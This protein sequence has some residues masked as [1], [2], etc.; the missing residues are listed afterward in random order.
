[1][2]CCIRLSQLGSK[3][4]YMLKRIKRKES[5]IL[6]ARKNNYVQMIDNNHDNPKN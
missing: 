3:Q 2:Y 1:M 5:I 4:L 6:L